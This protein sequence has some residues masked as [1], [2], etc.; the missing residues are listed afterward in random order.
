MRLLQVGRDRVQ[1]RSDVAEGQVGARTAGFVDQKIED[2]FTDEYI[3]EGQRD[4]LHAIQRNG[5]EISDHTK[6]SWSDHS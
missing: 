5:T 2:D 3:W 6:R 1:V 4:G